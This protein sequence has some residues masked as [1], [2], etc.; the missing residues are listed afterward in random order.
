MLSDG[1]GGTANGTVTVNITT[2]PDT[3][4]NTTRITQEPAPGG[5]T[6]TR[7]T[8]AGIPARAYQV[9]STDSLSPA[10]WTTRA[11]VTANAQGVFE[12]ID[13][14]PPPAQRFYRSI[15]P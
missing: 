2:N 8:F 15:F 14:P 10:N 12:F 9:Q 13:P 1:N 11:T 3:S 6:Q 7:V 4:P 5:G